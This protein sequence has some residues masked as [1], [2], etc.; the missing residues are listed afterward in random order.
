[1]YLCFWLHGALLCGLSL[2]VAVG[3]CSLG[4]VQGLLVLVASLVAER[5]LEL[6][7]LQ[8]LLGSVAVTLGL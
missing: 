8:E 4:A 6:H 5:E 7:G 1:M 2:V 3:G